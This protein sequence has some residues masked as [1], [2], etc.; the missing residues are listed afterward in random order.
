MQKCHNDL[1]DGLKY[2][3]SFKFSE[4]DKYFLNS[5]QLP[6]TIFAITPIFD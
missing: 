5:G 1:S 2:E 4:S 3:T 6:V